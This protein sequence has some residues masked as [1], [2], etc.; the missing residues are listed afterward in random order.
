MDKT[1]G[2][3][4]V[5]LPPLKTAVAHWPATNR[6]VVCGAGDGRPALVRAFRGG[7]A[8]YAAKQ[9]STAPRFLLGGLAHGH[10]MSTWDSIPF[11]NSAHSATSRPFLRLVMSGNA[12][13]R[14]GVLG[15]LARRTR[16]SIPFQKPVHSA[17]CMSRPC[18]RRGIGDGAQQT[19]GPSNKHQG[20]LQNPPCHEPQEWCSPSRVWLVRGDRPRCTSGTAV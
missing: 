3:P 8:H 1:I 9:C 12:R 15:G 16:D 13:Q 7:C 6:R 11:Q 17:I 19:P 20:H 2:G 4:S 14:I 5:Q 18:L 10:G